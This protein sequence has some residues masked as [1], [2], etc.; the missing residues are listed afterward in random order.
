ML[1]FY[2]LVNNSTNENNS[3]DITI[4]ASQRGKWQANDGRIVSIFV[5][6]SNKTIHFSIPN[7]DG[8]SEEKISLKVFFKY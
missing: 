6:V 3:L 4:S 2:F 8:V 5:N 1:S 7:S